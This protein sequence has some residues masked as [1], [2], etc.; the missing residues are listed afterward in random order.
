MRRT[1]QHRTSFVRERVSGT[2]GSAN[3]WH[4]NSALAGQLQNLAQRYFEVLLDI[5]AQRLERRNV[6]DLRPV[7][8][9]SR[10]GLANQLIDADEK[11]CES[12]AGA[13]R[14]RNQSAFPRQDVRPALN[15]RFCRRAETS[16]KPIPHQRVRPFQTE[17]TAR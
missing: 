14:S 1:P 6:N 13:C 4:E 10:Q 3:L 8:Q 11:C 9:L 17:R 16:G 2:N 12:L 15:L 7:V 5:V